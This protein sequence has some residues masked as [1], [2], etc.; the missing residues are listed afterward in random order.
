[1]YGFTRATTTVFAAAV[2]GFLLWFATQFSNDDVGDYWARIGLVAGAGL[3]MALSQL[4]GG[5]TKWGFP[6]VSIPVL[7]LAFVPVAVVSL[8]VIFAGEPGAGWF[9]NHA[10]SWTRDIHVSGLVTDMLRYIP[11][12]AFGTGL[13]LGY[14]FDTT[15]PRVRD[16]EVVDRLDAP[17]PA[18]RETTVD[19]RDSEPVAT[20]TTSDGRTVE[21]MAELELHRKR[22]HRVRA[23]LA[24]RRLERLRDRLAGERAGTASA[25]NLQPSEGASEIHERVAAYTLAHAQDQPQG[26]RRSGRNRRSAIDRRQAQVEGLNRSSERRAGGERRSGMSRRQQ[27]A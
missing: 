3:V 23:F 9:H 11:V 6:R 27:G 2:A 4:L 25:Q 10:L 21:M 14:S 7:V 22:G 15:G 13:V 18:D 17:P 20:T 12:L 26:E 16:R 19:T 24:R 1:M 5:W 8:L